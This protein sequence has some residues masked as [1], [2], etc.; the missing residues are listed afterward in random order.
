VPT[1]FTTARRWFEKAAL[2]N[3]TNAM[4]NLGQMIEL[5]QGGPRNREEARR[6]YEKAREL[7]NPNAAK[8]LAR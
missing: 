3:E 6:W 1:D 4:V 7:G 8:A 5:G 2:Q